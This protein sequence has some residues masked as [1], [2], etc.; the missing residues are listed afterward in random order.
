MKQ[1]S[2]KW[3]ED[4]RFILIALFIS[5]AGCSVGISPVPGVSVHIPLPH[6]DGYYGR[7]GEHHEHNDEYKRED[8]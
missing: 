5:L 6:N 2:Y 8:D 1:I 4:M 7:E 3:R